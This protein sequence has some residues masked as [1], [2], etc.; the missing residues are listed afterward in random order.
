MLGCVVL[1]LPDAWMC[2]CAQPQS[3]TK[4]FPLQGRPLG[5]PPVPSSSVIVT[6]DR[7][8]ASHR[9]PDSI[10]SFS[11]APNYDYQVLVLAE[12]G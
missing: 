7:R 10:H 8:S 11:V 5:L 1:L 12:A 9:L 2:I 3:T 6:T 4:A